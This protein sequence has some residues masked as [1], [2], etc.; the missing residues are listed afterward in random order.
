MILITF[1]CK[2]TSGWTP[3]GS[4]WGVCIHTFNYHKNQ[5]FMYVNIFV[6][7]NIPVPWIPWEHISTCPL[8]ARNLSSDASCRAPSRSWRKLLGIQHT[9][10]EDR[11]K[12]NG[13]GSETGTGF[14]NHRVIE[15]YPLEEILW[16]L[17]V[18][19]FKRDLSFKIVHS[20]MLMLIPSVYL[21]VKY[22]QGPN[23][24]MIWVHRYP[25]G[26]AWNESRILPNVI[27]QSRSMDLSVE[28]IQKG[29]SDSIFWP[30]NEGKNYTW[31]IL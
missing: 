29:G 19:M 20:V 26:I 18:Y 10:V 5:P 17:K 25:T 2:K 21:Q 13:G 12:R 1:G 28:R 24:D 11:R 6:H 15:R 16:H 22:F 14:R 3:I 4:M 8:V 23:S 9:P 27:M 30:P 7:V 31:H